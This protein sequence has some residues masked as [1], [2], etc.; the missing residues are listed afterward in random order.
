MGRGCIFPYK[1]A[2]F[3][4]ASMIFTCFGVA[5]ENNG[6]LCYI[7]TEANNKDPFKISP[8]CVAKHVFRT[9]RVLKM[10]FF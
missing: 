4:R 6:L 1:D 5:E 3:E 8:L 7:E 2:S 9:Q 10:C